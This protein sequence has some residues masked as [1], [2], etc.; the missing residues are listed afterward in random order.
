MTRSIL[1]VV[2]D[3][4]RHEV[5]LTCLFFLLCLLHRLGEGSVGLVV[6]QHG[7]NI[8]HR[9]L[10]DYIHTALQVESEAD[11]HFPALLK[12]ISSEIHFLVHD[13]VE[14]L[15][16]S[17]LAH[18]S[19]FVLIVACHEREGKIEY[20]HQYQNQC[21]KLY[22]SFVLHFVIIIFLIYYFRLVA[23]KSMQI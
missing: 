16:S 14:V 17:L 2:L 7:N 10:E 11:F 20:T 4:E 22:N 5:C 1:L 12:W 9:H 3:E 18:G 15:L 23:K 8:R 6:S 21:D 19:R 13:R